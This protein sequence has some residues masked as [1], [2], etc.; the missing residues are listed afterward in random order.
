MAVLVLAAQGRL[1]Y[2]AFLF[3]NVGADSENPAT[4][5]YYSEY[6]VPYAESHGLPLHELQRIPKKGRSAGEVE[7]LYGRLTRDGSRSLPI[8]VRMANGAP[9][10]RGCTADF[11]IRVIADWQRQHGATK[12]DP[13]IMGLGISLDEIIR[14]RTDSG[15][16]WQT[17]EY[18]L[19]DLRLTATDCIQ[20]VQA[21]GLPVPPKSSCWF[22]P[23]HSRDEWVRMRREEPN[24][25]QMSVD[26]ENQLNE[27]RVLL[28]KDHIYLHQSARPLAQVVGDQMAFAYEED[29]RTCDTGHC[30]I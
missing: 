28:G 12:H 23:F 9:G 4:L 11:K 26:L 7:T 8:P 24:L 5:R 17:L 30:F 16:A 3:A 22:C 6:A 21:A 18:P 20:I 1:Q 29:D 25:F 19:L 10:R 2:D 13:A 15:I 27:R 14:A